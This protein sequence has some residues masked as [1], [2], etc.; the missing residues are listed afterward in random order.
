VPEH[1]GMSRPTAVME[2]VY[3][4]RLDYS[5]MSELAPLVVKAATRGDVVARAM[6]DEMVEEIVVT[7]N[8]AIKRLRLADTDVHVVLGGGVL[9]GAQKDVLDRIRA[10][11]QQVAPRARTL[12]LEAPP[13]LGAALIGLDELRAPRTAQGRLR[14]TLTD[15]RFAP[16]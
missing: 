3:L 1:F 9:R 11:I 6:L 4:G 8:A 12:P 13:V 15:R 14:S 10:G 16:S 2:A 7:A 5:R